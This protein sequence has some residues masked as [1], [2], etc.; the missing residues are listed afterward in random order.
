[1]SSFTPMKL[2]EKELKDNERALEKSISM[3]NKGVIDCETHLLHKENLIKLITLYK[4]A[5]NLL[6]H[7]EQFKKL[8]DEKKNRNM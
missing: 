6:K 4:E 5:I 1:M 8:V 2:L 7:A 3:Y